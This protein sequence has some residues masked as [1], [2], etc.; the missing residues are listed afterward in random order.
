MIGEEFKNCRGRQALPGEK[1]WGR[2]DFSVGGS[3]HR[4]ILPV[5]NTPHADSLVFVA[6]PVPMEESYEE[7]RGKQAVDAALW[8]GRFVLGAGALGVLCNHLAELDE[9]S[10]MSVMAGMSRATQAVR[11]AAQLSA[12]VPGSAG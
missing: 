1:P 5:L 12:L 9:M 2:R 7:H 3:A 4:T 11:F 6:L 8:S 10:Q